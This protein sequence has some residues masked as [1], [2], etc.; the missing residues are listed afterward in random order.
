[1]SWYQ[2]LISIISAVL[3]GFIGGWV[4]AYRMG[5]W[6][7]SV[8]DRIERVQNRLS[9]GDQALSDVPVISTRLDVLF[10]ELHALRKE[11]RQARSESVTHEECDRRHGEAGGS[12]KRREK[13]A[14]HSEQ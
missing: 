4:V 5:R 10:D 13:N 2:S 7:Q 1:M 9:S 6:R 11:I 8:E 12:N 3:G 14:F